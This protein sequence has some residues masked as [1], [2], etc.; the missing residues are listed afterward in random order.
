MIAV[1]NLRQ[2]I[3]KDGLAIGSKMIVERGRTLLGPLQQIGDVTFKSLAFLLDG[4][5][6]IGDGGFRLLGP[7][8]NPC[9]SGG[10]PFVQLAQG[11]MVFVTVPDDLSRQTPSLQADEKVKEPMR[12]PD[13]KVLEGLPVGVKIERRAKDSFLQLGRS[14]ARRTNDDMLGIEQ[15]PLLA[16]NPSLAVEPFR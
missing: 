11:Q 1:V 14:H 12:P 3:V 6:H 15:M 9:L 2:E 16:E 10:L 5:A 13:E 4:D 8:L 7:L